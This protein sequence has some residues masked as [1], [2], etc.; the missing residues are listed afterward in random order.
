MAKKKVVMGQ[1]GDSEM[2]GPVTYTKPPE[3]PE[4]T[5][6]L[7]VPK[8]RTVILAGNRGQT[9]DGGINGRVFAIPCGEEVQVDEATYHAIQ[10]HI[11]QERE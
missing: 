6:N 10:A 2:A 8:T 7:D 9:L 11:I 5:I 4:I 3:V 1:D